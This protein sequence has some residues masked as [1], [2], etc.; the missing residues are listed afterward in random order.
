VAILR[1]IKEA[2]L[3]QPGLSQHFTDIKRQDRDEDGTQPTH[4]YGENRYE[5]SERAFVRGAYF[6]LR[7]LTKT[8]F[9]LSDSCS[10]IPEILKILESPIWLEDHPELVVASMDVICTAWQGPASTLLRRSDKF[11]EHVLRPLFSPSKQGSPS[12][13]D[14]DGEAARRK[15]SDRLRAKVRVL[16]QI[17]PG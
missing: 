16:S 10:C 6:A 9:F 12:G 14:E 5:A 7:F 13:K 1:L 11:W 17:R 4:I 8:F 15:R 2:M 3:Y